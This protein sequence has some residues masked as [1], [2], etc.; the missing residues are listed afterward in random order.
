[1]KRLFL[2]LFLMFSGLFFSCQST[3]LNSVVLPKIQCPDF[4]VNV[5]DPT[6]KI[7]LSPDSQNVMI[8]YPDEDKQLCLPMWFWLELVEYAADVDSAIEQYKAVLDILSRQPE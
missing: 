5:S 2:P 8:S 4:P 6:V 1:M 7:T 3:E